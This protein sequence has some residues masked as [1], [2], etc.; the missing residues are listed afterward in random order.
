MSVLQAAVQPARRRAVLHLF[1]YLDMRTGDL[2]VAYEP[3]YAAIV[4]D[5]LAI[6]RETGRIVTP[7][8]VESVSATQL[9][10]EL[11]QAPKFLCA[12]NRQFGK[13]LTAHVDTMI[14]CGVEFAY[15]AFTLSDISHEFVNVFQSDPVHIAEHNAALIRVLQA[16]QE[17]LVE[18]DR[19]TSLRVTFD[20]QYEWVNQDGYTEAD[21]DL[22][23]NL[24]M[25]EVATY[26]PHV[27][28]TLEFIGGLLGTIPIGRKYG[29]ITRPIHLRIEDGRLTEL[30][31]DDERLLADLRFCF[32][33]DHYTGQVNE[34]G[35]GTNTSITGPLR[36]FNYKHEESRLGFHLGF[37]ASLAQQNVERLTP[38]HLDL[39]LQDCRLYLD[40]VLL[41]DGDYRFDQFP[42]ATAGT[43]LRTTSR[44]CCMPSLGVCE[45]GTA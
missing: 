22:T 9:A 3:A 39:L 26:T 18:D 21:Y 16:G 17:L 23:M 29:P 5:I 1:D 20:Q 40:G 44:S 2:L 13:G 28:G 14:E 12:F 8:P 27:E 42:E 24:P 34:I 11:E 31:T 41:F 35:F 7:L 38:H 43:P 32:D 25:G 30:S 4:D 10:S 19:G 33:F 45:P 6:A 37:G 36:G 15:K